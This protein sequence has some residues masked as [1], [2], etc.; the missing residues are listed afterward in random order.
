MISRALV[1]VRTDKY[2]WV[3]IGLLALIGLWYCIA[4]IF[5]HGHTREIEGMFVAILAIVMGVMTA[6]GLIFGKRMRAVVFPD[7][8]PVLMMAIMAI[9]I[10]WIIRLG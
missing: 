4:P 2:W 7:Q 8:C 5:Y 9:A 1:A 6:F 10:S 3:T